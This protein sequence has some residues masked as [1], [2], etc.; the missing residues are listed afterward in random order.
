MN[1]ESNK[2]MIELLSHFRCGQCDKWWSISDAPAA[3]TNWFC[4]WC[5]KE[6]NISELLEPQWSDREENND[7]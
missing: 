7:R 2:R 1:N 4:P 3:K 5:G 6:Q